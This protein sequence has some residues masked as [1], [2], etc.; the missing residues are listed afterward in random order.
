M[1]SLQKWGQLH[2]FQEILILKEIMHAKRQDLPFLLL[3]RD[4]SRAMFWIGCKDFP[5]KT[6]EQQAL[7]SSTF[8]PSL[9]PLGASPLSGHVVF[10]HH[11]RYS[12]DWGNGGFEFSGTRESF[13]LKDHGNGQ[14][15]SG[16]CTECRPG[17]GPCG[18]RLSFESVLWLPH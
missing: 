1:D 9:P 2:S 6:Q 14:R 11:S 18:R 12:R 16:H 13:V 5:S 4:S 8:Q 7:S 10:P 3:P 17:E 15:K